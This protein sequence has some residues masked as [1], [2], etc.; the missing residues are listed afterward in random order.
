MKVRRVW[1]TGIVAIAFATGAGSAAPVQSDNTIIIKRASGVTSGV[2]WD[3]TLPPGKQDHIQDQV[4]LVVDG[5]SEGLGGDDMPPSDYL[6]NS[7]KP[8]RLYANITDDLDGEVKDIL[9][10]QGLPVKAD[11]TTYRIHYGVF[12]PAMYSLTETLHFRNSAY[13]LEFQNDWLPQTA[14]YK[15]GER[16]TLLDAIALDSSQLPVTKALDVTNFLH[17]RIKPGVSPDLAH[18]IMIQVQF[19]PVGPNGDM[20]TKSETK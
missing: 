20:I 18:H 15:V 5:K 16:I 11:V 9:K 17:Q 6:K 4:W 19:L 3:I 1:L 13:L 7:H 2:A 14:R 10:A 8:L 12:S